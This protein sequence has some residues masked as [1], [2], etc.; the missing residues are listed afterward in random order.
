MI[1]INFIC[2]LT[3]TFVLNAKANFAQNQNGLFAEQLERILF[4]EEEDRRTQVDYDDY[5]PSYGNFKSGFNSSYESVVERPTYHYKEPSRANSYD[6]Y[7]ASKNNYQ[8]LA[9]NN[10]DDYNNDY[11]YQSGGGVSIGGGGAGYEPVQQPGSNQSFRNSYPSGF[12]VTFDN[13]NPGID[14][15][16][17]PGNPTDPDDVPLDGG[18][19]ALVGAGAAYGASRLRKKKNAKE[20]QMA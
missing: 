13:G 10:F 14:V 5:P 20:K 17:S 6:F 9:Q 7:N 15:L 2:I 8:A 1:R 4:G 16:S 11:N 12:D 18:I 3:L 19:V